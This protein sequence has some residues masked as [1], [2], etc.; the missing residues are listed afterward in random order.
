MAIFGQLPR[1]LEIIEVKFVEKVM[2]NRET[3]IPAGSGA[4]GERRGN[5]NLPDI[6]SKP[7]VAQKAGGI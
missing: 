7:P 4:R 3:P 1:T 5:G 6:T 2:Y